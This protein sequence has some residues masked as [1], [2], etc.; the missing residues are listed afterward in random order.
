MDNVKQRE[1][2]AMQSI[3][4]EVTQEMS[5]LRLQHAHINC[6]MHTSNNG[7]LYCPAPDHLMPLNF[8]DFICGILSSLV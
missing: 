7:L 5:V 6:N 4:M 3:S 2:A 8:G 1:H